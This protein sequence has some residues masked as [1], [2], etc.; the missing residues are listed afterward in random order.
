[1]ATLNITAPDG[2][3]LSIQVPAGTDPSKYEGIV[4]E[5]VQHY[6]QTTNDKAHAAG[7]QGPN[8]NAGDYE[9]GP[10]YP[11]SSYTTDAP[12]M[13]IA[14]GVQAAPSIAKLGMLGARGI[15]QGLKI[16]GEGVADTLS[17][18][19]GTIK[20]ALPNPSIKGLGYGAAQV[21]TEAGQSMAKA[22]QEY[23]TTA[24]P[25]L[26]ELV[27]KAAAPAAEDTQSLVTRAAA[28]EM[29]EPIMGASGSEANSAANTGVFNSPIAN[30]MAN[31]AEE[32]KG[33]AGEQWKQVGNAIDNTLQGLE[34]TGE[35]FDPAPVLKQI[36]GMYERD[37]QGK[38]MTTGWQGEANQSI[39]EALESM[40][41]YANGDKIGWQAAN[42]IKS[43]LQDSAS[44][45]SKRFDQAN[46]AYKTVA[47]LI[48]TDIDNQA[49]K[50]LADHGG[51]VEDFQHLRDAYSKLSSLRSVLTPAAGKDLLQPSLG[52]SIVSGA[53][54]YLPFGIAAGLTGEVARRMF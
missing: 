20:E 46:E 14:M 45:A 13:D 53:K 37:A 35:K 31:S 32:M 43:G 18:L 10:N 47:N 36:E 12:S 8:E 40:K 42:R 33:L 25:E 7:T 11:A 54:K 17:D 19:P 3:K 30:G 29:K 34:R 9:R 28:D 1:M 41:D 39:G 49:A 51:N 21:G 38:L 26:G 52:E 6:T 44:Y 48:K 4:D 50:V 27:A 24:Q 16:A 2:K 22:A 5:V 15:G 23:A